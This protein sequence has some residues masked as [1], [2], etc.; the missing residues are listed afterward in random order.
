MIFIA[1]AAVVFVM[2]SCT[3]S[4]E[5]ATK[6][7]LQREWML[8]TLP[9]VS[10]EALVAAKA[11]INLSNPE[12]NGAYGGCN[13]IFF[14]TKTDRK[15]AIRFTNMGSTKMYC[16]Q[17]M[18]IEDALT[19]ALSEVARYELKGHEIS[20][21]NSKGEVLMTAVASDWD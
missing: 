10:Y 8:K 1:M 5:I 18:H 14:T 6:G 3:N 12:A 17:T 13:R 20:F 4:K 2:V 19:K 15:N 9:G 21:K 16:E 7:N 11:A